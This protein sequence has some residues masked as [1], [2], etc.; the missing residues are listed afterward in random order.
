M[1]D[2]KGDLLPEE[3]P[4]NGLT[5]D[6]RPI[7]EDNYLDIDGICCFPDEVNAKP[8]QLRIIAPQIGFSDLIKSLVVDTENGPKEIPFSTWK[9]EKVLGFVKDQLTIDFL[10]TTYNGRG[11]LVASPENPKAL[12]TLQ[13]WQDKYKTDALALV[14]LMRLWWKSTGGGVQVGKPDTK[15]DTKYTVLGKGGRTGI[16]G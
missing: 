12:L 6:E 13:E 9:N 1:P 10:Q 16:R 14:L 3:K 15:A 8:S 5:E 11:I 4:E 2:D 7:S